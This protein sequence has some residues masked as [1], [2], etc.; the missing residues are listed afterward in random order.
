MAVTVIKLGSSIVADEAGEPRVDVLRAVC[1]E[2]C[3][4]HRRAR[5]W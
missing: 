3:A 2:V 4:L 5:T 1:A